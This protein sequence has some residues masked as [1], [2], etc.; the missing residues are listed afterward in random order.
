M[1]DRSAR[2]VGAAVLIVFVFFLGYRIWDGLNEKIT[3]IDAASV[4]VEDLVSIDGT[5]LRDQI[6]IYGTTEDAEYLIANGDKVAAGQAVCIYFETDDASSNYKR[7]KEIEAEIEAVEYIDA[8]ITSG[9]DSSKFDGMIYK[10]LTELLSYAEDGKISNIQNAYAS[11]RQLVIARDAGVYNKN[12]FKDKLAELERERELYTDLVDDQSRT[13]V[14]PYSGYFFTQTD[15]YEEYFSSA[16]IENITTEYLSLGKDA[17][18]D[19][20][21]DVIGSVVSSFYW[22][23]AAE[24]DNSQAAKLYGKETVDAYIPELSA[25]VRS[26]DIDRIVKEGSDKYVLVLKSTVMSPDYLSTRFQ[27]VDIIAGTYTGIK[28]PVEALHQK[29]GK[30]GVY[31]LEGASAK[32]KKADIIYQTDSYYLLEMAESAA[33]GLYL[34]DKIIVSGKDFAK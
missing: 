16:C 7:L 15:G 26:Y 34:Y 8:Y 9:T 29:D 32:F 11:L 10:K 1:K 27:P 33:K 2:G 25:S 21:N 4:T 3:T 14:S 12:V 13:V 6:V 28:V 20:S 5:F 19:L 31:C 18:T 22:Y 17:N 30:W 24:I 23:I